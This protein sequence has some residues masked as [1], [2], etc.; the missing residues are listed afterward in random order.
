MPSVYIIWRDWWLDQKTIF[1]RGGGIMQSVTATFRNGRVELAA[2]VDWPNGTPLEVRPLCPGSFDADQVT[3]PITRWPEGFFDR[4]RKT[5]VL[6]RSSVHHRGNWK[7][8]S[9]GDGMVA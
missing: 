2:P 6:N 4:L 7:D 5:G 1:E 8:V 3:P 9:N